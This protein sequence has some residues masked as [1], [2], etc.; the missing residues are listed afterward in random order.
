M[1]LLPPL[2]LFPPLPLRLKLTWPVSQSTPTPP[3]QAPP[4]CHAH[5]AGSAAVVVLWSCYDVVSVVI[6]STGSALEY[7]NHLYRHLS[8]A[9]SVSHALY[10]A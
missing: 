1:S 6:H 8:S 3:S 2:S 7:G 9:L 4:T 10:V 5:C